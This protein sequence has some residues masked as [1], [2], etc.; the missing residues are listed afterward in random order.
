MKR[1][2]NLLPDWLIGVL[3]TLIILGGLLIGWSPLQTLEYKTYDLRTKF[4]QQKAS[5]PVVIVAIDDMSI[6]NIGRWPWPRGYIA[7]M[8]DQLAGYGA[9]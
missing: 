5:S 9:K 2:V 6:A 4:R 8:I 1:K 7:A 3:L